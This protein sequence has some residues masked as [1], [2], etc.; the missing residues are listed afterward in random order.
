MAEKK[1]F[2]SEN[3]SSSF[4]RIR[5]EAGVL[6]SA[7]WC[8]AASTLWCLNRS[9]GKTGAATKPDMKRAGLLQVK[10]LWADPVDGLLEMLT[11][12]GLTGKETFSGMDIDTALRGMANKPALY[13]FATDFHDGAAHMLAC[14]TRPGAFY[15]YDVEEGCFSYASAMEMRKGIKSR[16]KGSRNTWD[17]IK[18]T[19]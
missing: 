10:Y 14:D 18:V 19:A 16:Y 2:D 8:A 11:S 9:H 13:F 17:A 4:Q 15:F 6:V 1:H 12:I 3:E 5:G 7:G